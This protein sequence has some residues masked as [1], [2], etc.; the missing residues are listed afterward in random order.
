MYIVGP[1]PEQLPFTPKVLNHQSRQPQLFVSNPLPH[2]ESPE[3]GVLVLLVVAVRVV[4]L[5]VGFGVLGINY[6]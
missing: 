5:I 2:H 1:N 6:L 3:E 4:V